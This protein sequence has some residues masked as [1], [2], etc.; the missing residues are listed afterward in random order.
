MAVPDHMRLSEL[1]ERISSAVNY[2]FADQTFWV[3]ADVTDLKYY[4]EKGYYYFELVE[5]DPGSNNL[6]AKISTSAWGKASQRIKLFEKETGQV[7]K[8]DINILVSVSVDY[9]PV[10]GLKLNLVDVD[11]N[12]TIG[13]LEKQR[14][15]TLKRLL[16]ECA[17]FIKKEGENYITLNNQ[18]KFK[19][20]IQKIAVITSLNSAGFQDF[21]HT[22]L[23]NAFG[24]RFKIDTFLAAVQ[25]GD[26][27]KDIHQRFIDVYESGKDYDAV[28]IIRG[29]GAQTDFLIFD[30]FMLG[31]I[32]AKFPIPVITGI[33]HQKNETIVDLMAHTPTKTPTKAAEFIIAHNRYF[34][35]SLFSFQ[36]AIIIKSQQLFGIHYRQITALSHSVSANVQTR[37]TKLKESLVMINQAVINKS[38]S[39]VY[40]N[41]KTLDFIV[42]MILSKPKLVLENRRNNLGNEASN[43]RIFLNKYMVNQG[44][45][46]VHYRSV[47]SLI[48][49]A[50]LVK[51]GFAVV[52]YKGKIVAN[53]DKI[54][55]GN[56][57]SVLLSDTELLSTV[58]EKIKKNGKEPYL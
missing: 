25:G 35:E 10:Y 48:S 31:R 47:F 8:N 44:S 41:L 39:L 3:I 42:N 2:F 1:T 17:G 37:I 54:K 14:L 38:K 51:K 20:V 58:K 4:K 19:P 53:A 56:D 33:G 9:H 55:I 40:R 16:A 15:E 27:A 52:Y 36:K 21:Q 28:V 46:L 5:K 13:L 30:T 24:Y 11:P 22:L 26:N 50:N 57:I 6:V 43:F 34:E 7:F 18:L 49:P 23:T 32:V 45:Y 29:G 12:F